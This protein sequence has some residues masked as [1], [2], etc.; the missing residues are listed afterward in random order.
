[1]SVAHVFT[2]CD[3]IMI[4]THTY[5]LLV[6]FLRRGEAVRLVKSMRHDGVPRMVERTN[7]R[8]AIRGAM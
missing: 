7:I 4:P 6:M 3:F 2:L 1:M 8:M 5:R